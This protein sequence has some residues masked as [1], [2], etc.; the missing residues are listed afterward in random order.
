MQLS[1]A[2]TTKQN[3]FIHEFIQAKHASNPQ[4]LAVQNGSQAGERLSAQFKVER[5]QS[6]PLI[7]Q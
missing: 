2:E 4:E 3:I 7:A 5:S 6:L 1:V